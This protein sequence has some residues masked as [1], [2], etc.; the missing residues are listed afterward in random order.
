MNDLLLTRGQRCVDALVQALV[1]GKRIGAATTQLRVYVRSLENGGARIGEAMALRLKSAYRAAF[2]RTS[3][4]HL[5]RAAAD[6]RLATET[7]VRALEI[8]SGK[9]VHVRP[10]DYKRRKRQA[11]GW[12]V[13]RTRHG[14]WRVS[15]T[16]MQDGRPH[17][18]KGVYKNRKEAREV[19][20]AMI[21]K[22]RGEAA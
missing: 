19:A 17:Q 16:S 21:A 11:K 8:R 12:S 13:C 1:H 15:L 20:Q 6:A 9:S 5:L 14:G 18:L 22:L 10:V 3:D 2:M 7:Y 4:I